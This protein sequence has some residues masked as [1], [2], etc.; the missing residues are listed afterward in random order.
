VLVRAPTHRRKVAWGKKLLWPGSLR[1]V[2]IKSYFASVSSLQSRQTRLRTHDSVA[3]F[4]QPYWGYLVGYQ[5]RGDEVITGVLFFGID[6]Q[7]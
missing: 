4:Q 6:P 1:A 3:H 2:Y 5:Q 7:D